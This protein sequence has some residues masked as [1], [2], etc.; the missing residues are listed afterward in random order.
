MALA[1]GDSNPACL[2]PP[3]LKR[4]ATR[5]DRSLTVAARKN[6]VAGLKN[7][8]TGWCSIRGLKPAGQ[9]MGSETARSWH[10][11]GMTRGM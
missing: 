6:R 1:V 3:P 7:I 2:S 8:V 5:Q 11:P 10:D 4:C 9:G